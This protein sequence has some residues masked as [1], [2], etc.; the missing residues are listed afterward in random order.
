MHEL[1][2]R[3]MKQ[4]MIHANPPM[5]NRENAQTQHKHTFTCG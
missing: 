1:V 4:T 5:R 2:D 3:P